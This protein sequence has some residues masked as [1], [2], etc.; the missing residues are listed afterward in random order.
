MSESARG[1]WEQFVRLAE[2]HDKDGL[3][4]MLGMAPGKRTRMGNRATTIDGIRFASKLEAD[5]YRE[6]LL[7]RQA[8]EVLY[9][10]RQVPFDVATAVVYRADF[11]VMWNRTGTPRENVTVE[12][13]KGHQTEVAR[14]KLAAVQD[15]Y[16]IKI[17][18][19]RRADV[20]K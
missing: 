13:T 16:G 14:V 6:L 19:L 12:D 11:V 17:T 8:G 2:K 9:F 1:K 20:R 7:L 5:R 10:L 15:R 3:A 18:V 4:R